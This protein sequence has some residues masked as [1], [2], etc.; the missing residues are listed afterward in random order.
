MITTTS[1]TFLSTNEKHT[2]YYIN[3]VLTKTIVTNCSTGHEINT[4][5]PVPPHN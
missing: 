1:K 3:G 2:S 4:Y 5:Y